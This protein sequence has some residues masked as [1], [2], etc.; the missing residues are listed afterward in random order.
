MSQSS[1]VEECPVRGCSFSGLSRRLF[2]HIRQVHGPTDWSS[3]LILRF[4][5]VQCAFCLHWFSRLNQHTNTCSA[6]VSSASVSPRHQSGFGV[7]RPQSQNLAPTLV[8]RIDSRP[9]P[10]L[11]DISIVDREAA[12]WNFVAS[13][14]IEDMLV[15]LP[16]RTVQSIPLKFR[17]EF[18]DCCSIPLK[19]VRESPDDVLA[20]K[21]LFLL[22]RMLLSPS[23]GANKSGVKS[24][25][26]RYKNFRDFHWDELIQL[27]RPTSAPVKPQ[28]PEKQLRNAAIR[29]AKCGELSKS[30]RILTSKGLAPASDETVQKLISKHPRG[31]STPLITPSSSTHCTPIQLSPSIIISAIRKSPRGSGTG[32]SGWRFEHMRCLLDDVFSRDVL[33]AALSFIA[34][35]KLPDPIIRLVSASRL[36]ALYLKAMGMS[37]QLPWVKQCVDWL[38]KL[39]VSRRSYYSPPSFLPYSMVWLLLGALRC[40]STTFVYFLRSILNGF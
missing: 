9:S 16:P 3:G 29:L 11:F 17:S 22:P 30:A 34:Q 4:N 15:S 38:L 18:R 12:A 21:L 33:I 26:A 27:N 10:P 35:G 37:A 7:G 32:P 8:D 28:D 31:D 14:S 2:G 1:A 39:Y 23:S 24:V 36:I 19:R 40:W 6:R 13:V 5:L 25:R 20:W